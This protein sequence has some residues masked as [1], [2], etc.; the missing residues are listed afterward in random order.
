MCNDWMDLLNIVKSQNELKMIGIYD[1]G[2]VMEAATLQLLK[3]LRETPHSPLPFAVGNDSALP[4]FH[5]LGLFPGFH[6]V[7]ATGK[8]DLCQAVASVMDGDRG[9]HMELSR[10]W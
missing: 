5:M 8:P 4:T 6:P 10:K 9:Y 2:E 3:Y 1:W 7:G